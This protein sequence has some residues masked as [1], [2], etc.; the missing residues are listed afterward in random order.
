MSDPVRR[1]PARSAAPPRP[2][3]SRSGSRPRRRWRSRTGSG[4]GVSQSERFREV[5]HVL[6]EAQPAHGLRRSVVPEHRRVLRQGHRHLHGAGRPLHATLSVLRRRARP[7]AAARP[8]GS[9]APGRHRG[10][11]RPE[12]CRHHQRR[13]RRPAR[14]RRRAFRRLHPRRARAIA[15]HAHRGADARLPRPRRGRARHPLRRRPR[16][17]EP[18]PRDGAA[19]LSAGA[20]R[21]RLRPFAA[22]AAVVPRSAAPTCRPSPA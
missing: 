10:A 4:C 8:A 16:R 14:R 15:G 17:D 6:R 3:A 20:S 22:P 11:A 5:K 19:P 1:R 13:P 12:L 18:Q 2:R 7:A 21:R 9:R